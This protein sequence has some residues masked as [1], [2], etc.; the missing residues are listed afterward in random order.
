MQ[1]ASHTVDASSSN[2]TSTNSVS[3]PK[4]DKNISQ[5][6]GP[7]SL[8]SKQKQTQTLR[9]QA[10]EEEKKLKQAK[11]NARKEKKSMK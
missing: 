9:G 1:K 8:P 4:P 5:Q 3:P 11:I 2:L 6:P 7:S 10:L